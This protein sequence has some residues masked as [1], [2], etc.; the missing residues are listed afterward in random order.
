VYCLPSLFRHT[1][2]Q[3]GSVQYL[4]AYKTICMKACLCVSMY[5]AFMYVC[6]C[7]YERMYLC[8]VPCTRTN[9]SVSQL[10]ASSHRLLTADAWVRSHCSICGIPG[11]ESDTSKIFLLVYKCHT[12]GMGGGKSEILVA[13]D[14]VPL[15]PEQKNSTMCVCVYVCRIHILSFL[16]HPSWHETINSPH[17][18]YVQLFI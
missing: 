6:V 14:I 10:K 4:T 17:S 11:S 9:H 16:S 3:K 7:M 8:K 5:Y 18:R 13:A 2:T 1:N 12:W 15:R